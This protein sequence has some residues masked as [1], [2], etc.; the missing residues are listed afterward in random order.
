V[1]PLF[2]KKTYRLTITI[3]MKSLKVNDIHFWGITA[4]FNPAKY[5]N[6]LKNYHIFREKSKSQGLN[7][8]T[9]E[10]A[11][12]DHPFELGNDDSEII[13]QIRGN[14]NNILWQKERLINIGIENLPSECTKFAWLDADIIF[15]DNDWI[16]KAADHLNNYN[17]IQL[18]DEVVFLEKNKL[19]AP[20]KDNIKKTNIHYRPNSS[21]PGI[22]S[23]FKNQNNFS[24]HPGFAWAARKE[25]FSSSGLFD[26]NP[27]NCSDGLMFYAFSNHKYLFSKYLS[28]NVIKDFLAWSIQ[29]QHNA[30]GKINYLPGK[31]YHLWH[32]NE[33]NRLYGSLNKILTELSFDSNKDIT[34][35]NNKLFSWTSNNPKL[36][37][38]IFNY[39][40]IRNEE[41]HLRYHLW[42]LI[43][44][45]LAYLKNIKKRIKR[46]IFFKSIEKFPNLSFFIRNNLSRFFLIKKEDKRKYLIV[47]GFKKFDEN[48]RSLLISLIYS[49]ISDRKIILDWRMDNKNIFSLYFEHNE[50][51]NNIQE[52][53]YNIDSIYPVLWNNF[54]N[55]P[56][57]IFIERYNI[58]KENIRKY[59]HIFSID[60]FKVDY[61]QK[62]V[63]LFDHF[64]N[65]S[66]MHI[67]AHN[68]KTNSTNA[69]LRILKE[70]LCF[71]KEIL[72]FVRE[73]VVLFNK[74]NELDNFAGIC[75]PN[76]K[77]SSEEDKVLLE[78]ASD[79]VHELFHPNKNTCIFIFTEETNIIN[80]FQEKFTSSCTLKHFLPQLKSIT[81]NE[82]TQL[83]KDILNTMI[84]SLCNKVIYSS[85]DASSRS[86]ASFIYN[87]NIELHDISTSPFFSKWTL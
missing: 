64:F 55:D 72:D 40:K 62:A 66:S 68:T 78:A 31:I 26:R 58:P 16:R 57:D 83:E 1:I 74:Q 48:I 27:L 70:N 82:F 5:R 32:G 50:I 9:I 86:L 76:Y 85:N 61:T 29:V 75:L 42:Y 22:A 8:I 47:K 84:L 73:V 33:K 10:L 30:D 24:G 17:I 56:G 44:S 46:K 19:S 81:E 54:I 14:N 3:R 2:I 79:K 53:A 67:T 41:D 60:L 36:K 80:F 25:I 4:Y 87:K 6:K 37:K 65:Y 38:K 34:I 63:I 7:L 49:E 39:F 52:D 15:E 59:Q 28:Q 71:K 45:I 20:R 43:L 12:N 18:F 23:T 69:L 77:I 21:S 51:L 11:F 35:D 13:I